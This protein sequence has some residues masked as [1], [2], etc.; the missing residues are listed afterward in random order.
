M[1]TLIIAAID[2]GGLKRE[3]FSL[4]ALAASETYFIGDKGYRFFSNNVKAIQVSILYL[5]T[6]LYLAV[7]FLL[8]NR[9]NN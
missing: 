2:Q 9:I 4:F 6:C 1:G 3:F 5:R 7:I 8:F